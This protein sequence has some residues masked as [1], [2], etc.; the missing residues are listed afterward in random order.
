[1]FGEST[2]IIVVVAS[3]YYGNNVIKT[4]RYRQFHIVSSIS[5]VIYIYNILYITRGTVDFVTEVVNLF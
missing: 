2:R 4:A 5:I 3:S 1:M